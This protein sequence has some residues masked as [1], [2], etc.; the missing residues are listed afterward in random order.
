[1]A[2]QLET[3]T[4]PPSPAKPASSPGLTRPTKPMRL[5]AY[6]EHDDIVETQGAHLATLPPTPVFYTGHYNPDFAA[7]LEM[8]LKWAIQGAKWRRGKYHEAA[9]E[10]LYRFTPPEVREKWLEEA[11]R[12]MLVDVPTDEDTGDDSGSEGDHKNNNKVVDAAATQEKP[13]AAEA[14][15]SNQLGKLPHR[16]DGLPTPPLSIQNAATA[17]QT[18]KR[19]R[20]SSDDVEDGEEGECSTKRRKSRKRHPAPKA[21]YEYETNIPEEI[22]NKLSFKT[23]FRLLIEPW[24]KLEDVISELEKPQ[25]DT[26]DYPFARYN[27]LVQENSR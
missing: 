15:S 2:S 23:R 9:D 18:R 21:E 7:D 1:M 27:R 8:R 6:I 13:T 24:L 12:N 3:P 16:A 14:S 17:I 26:P 19:R 11:R 4:S 10:Y 20:V 25:S 22:Y 5:H